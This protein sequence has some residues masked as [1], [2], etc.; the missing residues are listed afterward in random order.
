MSVLQSFTLIN[1]SLLISDEIKK[2]VKMTK[3]KNNPNTM[4]VKQFIALH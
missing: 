3:Q 2:I 1:L 4:L